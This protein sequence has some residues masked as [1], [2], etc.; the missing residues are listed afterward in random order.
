MPIILTD[1][2][3]FQRLVVQQLMERKDIDMK[4]IAFVRDLGKANWA[5]FDE[6]LVPRYV[7]KKGPELHLVLGDLVPP[8]EVAHFSDQEEEKD[9]KRRATSAA[10]FYGNRVKDYEN[11]EWMPDGNEALEEAIQGAS[12]IISC[13]GATRWSNIWSDYICFWRL[14]QRDASRWCRD[15]SH[16]FY[17]HYHTTRKALEYAEREQLKREAEREKLKEKGILKPESEPERL[18][19]IRISDLMLSKSP[20][21]F[22]PVIANIFH[23]MIFRYQDMTERILEESPLLDTIILRPGDLTDEERVSTSL[24]MFFQAS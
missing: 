14:F 8:Q 21:T 15:P 22:V 20:W 11:R 4:V 6:M 10:K 18:R 5:L 19:F 3:S 23:S 1:D 12:V 24:S 7:L 16:P 2:I 13:V 17:V 9:W